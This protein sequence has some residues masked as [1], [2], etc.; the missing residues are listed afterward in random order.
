[1][2]ERGELME[3]RFAALQAEQGQV[4]K[5]V[6]QYGLGALVSVATVG[7]GIARLFM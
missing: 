6:L 5:R 4:E 2:V 3:Q 1:V 7:L